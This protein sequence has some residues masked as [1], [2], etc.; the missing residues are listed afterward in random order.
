MKRIKN[1]YGSCVYSFEKD[2]DEDYF[3]IYNLYVLPEFRRMN[4][5]KELIKKAIF[6]IRKT[7]YQGEILIVA[8][9]EEGSISFEKLKNFYERMGLKVFQEYL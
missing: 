5:A 6:E 4:K 8:K 7:G 2:S 9:P 3:H 1:K